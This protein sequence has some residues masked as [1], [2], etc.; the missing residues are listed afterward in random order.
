[1]DGMHDLGGKQG[2]GPVRHSPEAQVFH[3]LTRFSHDSWNTCAL[4]EWRTGPKPCLP[5]RSCMPSMKSSC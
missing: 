4:G 2:F 3:A 5:P 1:M